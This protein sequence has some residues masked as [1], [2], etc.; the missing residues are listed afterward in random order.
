[1]CTSISWNNGDF[2]LGRN[3]DISFDFDRKI[4]VVPRNYS[5]TFKEMPQLDTH[6]AL[7]GTAMVINNYPLFAEAVNE[8]GVYMAGLNFPEIAKY[9]KSDN[10]KDN[11]TVN[12]FIPYILSKSSNIDDVYILLNKINLT[13]I[14][15]L[16]NIPIPSLHFIVSD[17]N[18]SLVVECTKTGMHIYENETGII[19]N[20]PTFD[21]QMHNLN[22]YMYLSNE[23]PTNKM[24]KEIELNH[25]CMGLGALGLPGDF[26]SQSRFVKAYFLKANSAAEKTEIASIAQIFHMLDAVAM[27]RGSVL[28]GEKF[29]ITVYSCCINADKGIYY[30]KTYDSS[31]IS[32]VYMYNEDLSRNELIVHEFT[33]NTKIFPIN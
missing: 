19:T 12:E 1:M 29:D 8:K 15:F 17:K 33:Q 24:T 28:D 31:A 32:A 21:M 9:N 2:Y 5:F 26:S 20:N 3:M 13:D 7:M 18:K 27:V 4:V 11:V 23:N 10:M 16:P 6:Y 30:F 22:N 25:Y 14:P